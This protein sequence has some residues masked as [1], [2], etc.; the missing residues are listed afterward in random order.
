M[1]VF[2]VA[3][4]RTG[5]GDGIDMGHGVGVAGTGR[6]A[7]IGGVAVVAGGR[8]RAVLRAGFVVIIR[9]VCEG[10]PI[11]YRDGAG[12]FIPGFIRDHD[13]LGTVGRLY[14]KLAVRNRNRRAVHGNGDIVGIQV[15][16]AGRDRATV[17]FAFF[18]AGDHRESCIQNDAVGTDIRNVARVVGELCIDRRLAFG[19]QQDGAG[20]RRKRNVY[21]V[22]GRQRRFPVIDIV[23]DGDRLVVGVA[24]M[25]ITVILGG[26]GDFHRIFK[27]RIIEE[28]GEQA[29]PSVGAVH[30]RPGGRGGILGIKAIGLAALFTVC[31][32]EITGGAAVAILDGTAR[33]AVV[34]AVDDMPGIVINCTCSGVIMARFGRYHDRAAGPARQRGGAVV[35]ILTRHMVFIHGG[36]RRVAVPH[37]DRGGSSLRVGDGGAPGDLPPHKVL[38]AGLAVGRDRNRLAG[39]IPA[40]A[41]AVCNRQ[42]MGGYFFIQGQ[43][44][45]FGGGFLPG[46]KTHEQGG[47]DRLSVNPQGGAA[48]IGGIDRGHIQT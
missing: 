8:F 4:L 24:L 41:F 31:Q 16:D 17:R 7:G 12:G 23:F 10:V 39:E 37:G 30:D 20:V 14:G 5:G 48:F 35:V 9:V 28:R 27:E 47:H 25:G 45:L 33:T 44:G 13:G 43:V 36:D 19:L 2:H 32:G 18:Q 3:R 15:F 11:V 22:I 26:E 40:A 21:E 6:R 42:G 1:P 46:A 34:A 29:F 38:G